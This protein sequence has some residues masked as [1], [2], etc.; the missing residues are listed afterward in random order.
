MMLIF[1]TVTLGFEQQQDGKRLAGQ[2]DSTVTRV[3]AARCSPLKAGCLRVSAPAQ[4]Q[5]S[6]RWEE[7]L[8]SKLEQTWAFIDQIDWSSSDS[9]ASLPFFSKSFREI[10]YVFVPTYHWAVHRD[11]KDKPLPHQ[12]SS[13]TLPHLFTK[14]S[15]NGMGRATQQGTFPSVDVEIKFLALRSIFKK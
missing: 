10:L 2:R 15:R 4:G 8:G 12:R 7:Q 1:P 9:S 3:W 11:P 5:G 14:P 13:P 6:S